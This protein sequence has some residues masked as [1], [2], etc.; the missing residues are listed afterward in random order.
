MQD[1]AHLQIPH[2]LVAQVRLSTGGQA[3]H[4]DHDF[5]LR[6]VRFGDLALG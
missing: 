6:I 5:G 2:E 3:H 4:R 1:D